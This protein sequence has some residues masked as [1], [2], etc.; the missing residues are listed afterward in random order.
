MI[1]T[2]T[3]NASLDYYAHAD[4]VFPGAIHKISEYELFPGGK[5]INVSKVL[6]ELGT[7]SVAWSF[8]A[9][10]TGEML[11]RMLDEDGIRHDFIKLDTGMTRINVK[12]R[13]MDDQGLCETDFN[14]TGLVITESVIKELEMRVNA[15]SRDDIV[16]ISGSIPESVTQDAFKNI[17]M[18]IKEAGAVFIADITGKYLET[19]L[20]CGPFMVKPNDT[21]ISDFFGRTVESYEDAKEAGRKLIDRGTEIALISMG[22]KGAV[23]C[24]DRDEEY[25]MEPPSGEVVSTIGAGDSMLAGFVAGY[26]AGMNVRDAFKQGICAGSAT[27]F[28]V[29][30]A[31]GIDIKRLV[32][33]FNI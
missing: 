7:D 30:L 23:L 29:S 26:F 31:K 2:L 3:F 15:L 20:E 28:C 14:G 17:L 24:T 13:T 12:L 1:Y 21:E 19:A 27:A 32:D 5:G 18:G 6:K 9:G 11:E 4:S 8:V 22:A 10:S 25:V 16:V 33:G